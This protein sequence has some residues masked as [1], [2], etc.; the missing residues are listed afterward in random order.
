MADDERPPT[1]LAPPKPDTTGQA[2]SATSEETDGLSPMEQRF[3]DMSASGDLSMEDM[4]SKLG[5]CSRTLRRWKARP[6]VATAIRLRTSEQMSQARAV[7]AAGSARAARSLVELSDGATIGDAPKVSASR[8]VLETTMK[9]VEVEELAER[10]D[11][12][13]ARLAGGSRGRN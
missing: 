9:L 2:A 1:L 4:A 5:V 11:E 6:E 13:E 10:L 12:L 7:L 3:V 8:A